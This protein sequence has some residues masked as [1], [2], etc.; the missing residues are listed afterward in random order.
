VLGIWGTVFSSTADE[1]DATVTALAGAITIPYLSLHGIDPGEAYGHWLHQLV[2]TATVE[3][4][5]DQGH[6]PHLV[7]PARF[8]QRVIDFDHLRDL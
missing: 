8:V 7:H 2:P 6:Y 3:V 5:P 1:L 4:W